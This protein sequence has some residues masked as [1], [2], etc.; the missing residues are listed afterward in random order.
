MSTL[1]V[2]DMFEVGIEIKLAVGLK[3]AFIPACTG[4]VFESLVNCDKP[5][6]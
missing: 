1:L 3:A 4:T 2:L 6:A 5:S